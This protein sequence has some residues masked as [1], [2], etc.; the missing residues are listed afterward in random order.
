MILINNFTLYIYEISTHFII[1]YWSW[2]VDDYFIDSKIHKVI[3]NIN[4]MTLYFIVYTLILIDRDF[5]GL[6]NYFG[7]L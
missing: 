5:E 3:I 1:Y 6:P 7:K 4:I 2:L